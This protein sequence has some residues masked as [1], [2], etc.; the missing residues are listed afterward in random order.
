MTRLLWTRWAH[1]HEPAF[2]PVRRLAPWGMHGRVPSN[3]RS[4]TFW[5]ADLR[6]GTDTGGPANGAAAYADGGPNGHAD[7]HTNGQADRHAG[8]EEDGGTG[9]CAGWCADP[10]M[11]ANS[12][13]GKEADGDADPETDR[14]T[15][16]ET[17]WGTEW[18]SDWNADWRAQ[19]Q[20]QWHGQWRAERWDAESRT[21]WRTGRD[22]ARRDGYPDRGRMQDT[23][24]GSECRWDGQWDGQWDGHS[25]GHANGP[26]DWPADWRA[27]WRADNQADWRGRWLAA[28]HP[29]WGRNFLMACIGLCLCLGLCLAL[30]LLLMV[31]PAHADDDP[32]NPPRSVWCSIGDAGSQ[33]LFISTPS[34]LPRTSR[35]AVYTYGG[36]FART[37]NMR[38]GM[39]VGIE[40]SY[41][42]AYAT[43]RRAAMAHAAL[44][45][46]MAD[47]NF[48][49]VSVGIF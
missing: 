30:C 35:M 27:E 49:I 23:D 41:C 24:G 28:R 10:G 25:G 26:A 32:D 47:Q 18:D 17:D 16:R 7:G 21:D 13:A 6:R 33:R 44:I 48:K 43:P 29:P 46:R 2:Y 37:V 20:A 40:G 8:A 19:W 39:H 34:R 36:R 12:Y 22:R 38:F 45:A 3:A 31:P 15:N 42:H 11:N 5:P 4:R 14:R 1:A 9:R